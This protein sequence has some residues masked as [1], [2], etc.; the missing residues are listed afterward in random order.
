MKLLKI[1]IS[2]FC[3]ALIT[4]NV[5]CQQDTCAVLTGSPLNPDSYR[6]V[7][8]ILEKDLD[9]YV[10]EISLESDEIATADLTHVKFLYWAGGPYLE[11]DPSSAAA[12][13][14]RQAVAGGMG[15]FGT[16]GGSLIAVE[17]TSSSRENQLKIFP[18]HQPFASGRG[19]RSY[20]MHREHPVVQNSSDAADFKDIEEIHY[21]GGGRDFQ[22]SVPGLVN[23]VIANDV[24][25][26]TPA[27]TTT[28]HGK[29]RVFL[30]V[31]HPE[32]SFIPATWKFVR[33]AA[34][35]CLGRSDPENN[36]TPVINATI[37]LTGSTDQQLSFSAAGSTD[38]EG[39]PIGFIW[40]FG[41]G[42]DLMYR[43]EESHTYPAEGT[44]T[45][46][47]TVCDGDKTTAIV[48][49]IMI[50]GLSSL[51]IKK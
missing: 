5:L 3:S 23:W 30:S 45:V 37:P 46:T 29:G 19:M 20:Q 9:C 31:A 50:K 42:S 48:K 47:L 10:M 32:R 43:P 49:Q 34:E 17:T 28:L 11:F 41:D 15:F 2:I 38:P 18:G 24:E 6:T 26:K 4:S 25:R 51:V 27:L 8:K 16:C 40:D 12:E 14:I 33:M 44:Y 22:P 1:L 35:W 7:K 36:Q 21:N 13:N 39:Y